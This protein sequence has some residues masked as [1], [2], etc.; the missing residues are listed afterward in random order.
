MKRSLSL[1]KA[2][3]ALALATACVTASL[4]AH[5]A[6]LLTLKG[7]A[8]DAR[9]VEQSEIRLSVIGWSEPQDLAAIEAEYAKYAGT[10]DHQAFSVFLQQQDTHGYLFTKAA[11]GHTIKYAWQQENADGTRLVLLVTPALKAR[12]PNMWK[13][14]NNDPAPFSVVEVRV[15]GDQAV[16]KSSLETAIETSAEGRLQ[17]ADFTG[18]V[19]FARLA[20]A[21]PYYLKDPG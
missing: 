6:A 3:R 17:L 8:V 12:T 20:D 7:A 9:S 11:T 16:M 14:P 15:E 4:G 18:T 2:G 13:T 21:T 19:E 10:Q 1:F 5:G